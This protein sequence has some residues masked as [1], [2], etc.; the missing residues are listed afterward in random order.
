MHLLLCRRLKEPDLE[1]TGKH[2]TKRYPKE[3]VD[4]HVNF[5]DKKAVTQTPGL[6]AEEVLKYFFKSEICTHGAREG[7][8]GVR[9]CT[10]TVH[11]VADQEREITDEG[12]GTGEGRDVESG[13]GDHVELYEVARS[14]VTDEGV[15][16]VSEDV[17]G[18]GEC[19]ALENSTHCTE[20]HE[21]P[22]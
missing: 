22:V 14:V 3:D 6:N 18:D 19:N 13:A 10:S 4:R 21:T 1:Y 15:G 5:I 12:R 17:H 9:E 11:G 20:E 7:R 16:D 2:R 8:V